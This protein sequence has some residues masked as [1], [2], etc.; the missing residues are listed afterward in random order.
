M[1]H[2]SNRGGFLFVAIT[3]IALAA[4]IGVAGYRYHLAQ[5]EAV[6]AAI[7]YYVSARAAGAVTTI[8]QWADE[9]LANGRVIVEQSRQF[10][11]VWEELARSQSKRWPEKART[12]AESFAPLGFENVFLIDPEGRN[13]YSLT[14][15]L[16]PLTDDLRSAVLRAEVEQ[17]PTLSDLH[18]MPG[19]S[20]AHLDLVIPLF[21]PGGRPAGAFAMRLEPNATLFPRL[22][23]GQPP[24]PSAEVLAVRPD[25]DSF[26]HISPL[27]DMPNAQL[28]MGDRIS[29]DSVAVTA[30][31]SGGRPVFEA[32]DYRGRRVIA[33]SLKVPGTT[34]TVIAK[35]DADE[36]KN[37]VAGSTVFT[38]VVCALLIVIAGLALAYGWRNQSAGLY[39][40]LYE[41]ELKRRALS[42]HYEFLTRHANDLIL[43][44]DEHGIVME[45]NERSETALGITRQELI[46]TDFGD[47]FVLGASSLDEIWRAV[48]EQDGI[49]YEAQLRRADGSLVPVEISA[50]A[51]KTEGRRFLQS[52]V[53]DLSERKAAQTEMRTVLRTT[54]DGFAVFDENMRLVEVNDAYCELAGVPRDQ[55]IG[56]SPL[57]TPPEDGLTDL[58][59]HVER[60]RAN[61]SD[62]WETWFRRWDGRV[63]DLDVSAQYLPGKDRVFVF[64]RDITV[65]KRAIRELEQSRMLVDRIVHTAPILVYILDLRGSRITFVNRACQEFFGWSEADLPKLAA[66]MAPNLIH[67]DDLAR[68]QGR[69][70]DRSNTPDGLESEMDYRCRRA[71]GE[72]RWLHTREVVF[73]RNEDGSP[74]ELLGMAGDVTDRLKWAEQLRETNEAL[75][76]I[77]EASPLSL[78]AIDL[79]GRVVRW[80]KASETMFGWTAQEALGSFMPMVPDDR[81]EESRSMR[82][83]VA[84]GGLIRGR[85]LKRKRK[86][87]S[88][89]DVSLWTAPVRNERGDAVAVFS[90][91]MDITEQKRARAELEKSQASLLHAHRLASLGN[92]ETNLK[93][94]DCSWSDSAFEILGLHPGEAVPGWETYLQFVHP[95]DRERIIQVRTEALSMKRG[96]RTD[97]RVVRADGTERHV[98][99]W[100]ELQLD[101]SGNPERLAG[102]IQDVTE[103]RMLEQQLW[104]SQKLET[105]GRLA[106]GIAHDF[107][108]L[109]TVINGYSDVLLGRVDGSDHHYVSEIRAAGDRAADLIRKLLAFSR[110]QILEPEL[111]NVNNV[112]ADMQS[113]LERLLGAEV[114]L[115]TELAPDLMPVLGDQVQIQQVL[116]NLAVNGRD[117]MP[118]GGV[119]TIRTRNTD[120]SELLPP[121]EPGGDFVEIAVADNG[122]GMSAEV[123]EHLFEPFYTT[124]EPGKGTGLGLPTVYG[125]VKQS[126]GVIEVDSAPGAGSTFRVYLPASHRAAAVSA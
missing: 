40:N 60:V 19:Q 112:V 21:A 97:H 64:V 13:A 42:G 36:V 96:Y 126:G 15:A 88:L 98:R 94:G 113:M 117:A 34:W 111:L 2:R 73:S 95:E 37:A 16:L 38:A 93:T 27:H 108:N 83:E 65:R 52:I 86:D 105:V 101:G 85:E 89:I 14:G 102:T 49:L 29:G 69:L 74:R 3:F 41:E 47:L 1:D 31:K 116:M 12:W 77:I 78:L 55:I 70:S 43:L 6:R 84:A 79:Q 48:S 53:R 121:S 33:S 8:A 66:E 123:K 25:G 82:Q 4:G 17:K 92:W 124:K 71:D 20:S 56:M 44:L 72:W 81:L 109:L 80:N 115:R 61:G 114:K 106:G 67:P 57:E 91:F 125:I 100:V 99:Q 62:R 76:A 7:R 119:L 45:V 63:F 122:T 58:A 9:R 103:Y 10:A 90:I 23:I 54:T 39:R 32:V 68:V 120:G 18:K 5:E 59:E 50:R 26:V 75:N 30:L 46:G 28:Q 104:Q 118:G 51:I 11:P 107:N 87:G 24:Y 22:Q 35:V 110:K